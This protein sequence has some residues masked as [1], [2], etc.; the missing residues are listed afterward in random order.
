MA[1]AVDHLGKTYKTK[2]EMC[3]YYGIDLTVFQQR[4]KRGWDLQRSL[5]TSLKDRVCKDHLGNKFDKFSV[6]ARHYGISPSVLY[7]RVRRGVPLEVAVTFKVTSKGNE[8]YKDYKGVEYKSLKLLCEAYGITVTTYE[9]RLYKGWGLKEILT[10]PVH[11]NPC[12]DH[13]GQVFDTKK[14]MLKYWGIDYNTYYRKHK[15]MGWSLEDTLTVGKK[16][17]SW[18]DH[19]G[20][21]YRT[22]AIMCEHY[23]ILVSTFNSRKAQGLSLE[24]CLTKEVKRRK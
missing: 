18:V 8:V 13:L 2:K 10:T 4:Q 9:S 20:K 21:K 17:K 15:L 12:K 7:N 6:M 24:E 16:R 3:E 5:S 23:G 11:Y 1:L 22:Q 19:L 14:Q